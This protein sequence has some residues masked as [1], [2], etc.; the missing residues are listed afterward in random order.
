MIMVAPRTPI[1]SV[2]DSRISVNSDDA[3]L[4]LDAFLF[5]DDLSWWWVSRAWV[6]DKFDL[7]SCVNDEFDD[8]L[9]SW[10]ETEILQASAMLMTSLFDVM[11]WVFDGFDGNGFYA[12]EQVMSC[13]AWLMLTKQDWDSEQAELCE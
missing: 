8:E 4:V 2:N 13:W 3:S 11:C 7:M 6:D 12:D 10:S 5:V 1:S 9:D